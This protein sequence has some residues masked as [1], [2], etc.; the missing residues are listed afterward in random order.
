LIGRGQRGVEV[1]RLI[2]GSLQRGGKNF[3]INMLRGLDDF[4]FG[5]LL[6]N[7]FES[8]LYICVERGSGSRR[9]KLA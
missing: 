9:W 5:L 2:A 3:V 6:F 4:V 1:T 7:G 8:G